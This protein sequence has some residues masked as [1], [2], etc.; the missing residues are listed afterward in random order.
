VA[1]CDCSDA[2][3]E[4]YAAAKTEHI[5]GLANFEAEVAEINANMDFYPMKSG[6]YSLEKEPNLQIWRANF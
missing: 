5:F 6:C 1:S 4:F 3:D 2:R